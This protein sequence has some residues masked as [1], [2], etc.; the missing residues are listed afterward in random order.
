M[1][2]AIIFAGGYGRRMTSAG[3]PKQ[4]LEF[5]GKPI[6]IY[7]LELF[8]SHPEIGGIVV[9]CL[10]EWIPFLKQKIVQFGIRKVIGIVPGGETGQESI[11]LALQE[12][13]RI[14]AGKDEAD[15]VLIHDGV[16]PLINHQTITDNIDGVH[17]HGSCI[18]CVSATESAIIQ[19]D[20][21]EVTIPSRPH[22]YMVRA[23]QSFYLNDIL[24][25]Q[26]QAISEGRLDFVDS[27]TMMHY[28]GRPVHICIGP[29]ENIKIT[30]TIDY[31]V[32]KAMVES[33]ADKTLYNG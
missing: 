12:A 4:F 32:F 6:I 17:Q 28:Y 8:D 1:N 10:K 20:D 25:L 29:S 5:A 3:R 24:A 14:R 13:E 26:R 27:C 19:Q 9:A 16:R 33:L 18:T 11:F 22:M 23:P 30:T 15:I 31:Y 7:T 2:I 21:G